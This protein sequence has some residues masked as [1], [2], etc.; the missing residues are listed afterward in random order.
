MIRIPLGSSSSLLGVV[1]CSSIL[2]LGFAWANGWFA[3]PSM[4]VARD[5]ATAVAQADGRLLV[6][7]GFGN[8]VVSA[9]SEALDATG[10]FAPAATMLEARRNHASI[11]LPDGRVLVAGGTTNSGSA[12]ASAEIH[13]PATG[14]WCAVGAMA[15][16]RT[17]GTAILLLD[18]RAL[19]IGRASG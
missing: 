3:G 10:V 9:T 7:G 12:T 16:A 2:T 4:S 15:Q 17:K 8:G 14:S 6:S 1:V 13:D 11:E 19:K 5:G 18:G